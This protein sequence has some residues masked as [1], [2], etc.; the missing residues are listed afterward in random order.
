MSIERL[1][2]ESMQSTSDA[3]D[4][5]ANV[6]A[7]MPERARLARSVAAAASGVAE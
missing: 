6:G 5:L 4:T 3:S 2:L 7:V 1:I